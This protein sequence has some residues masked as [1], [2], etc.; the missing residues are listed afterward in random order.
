MMTADGI[1]LSYLVAAAVAAP[2]VAAAAARMHRHQQTGRHVS[3]PLYQNRPAST[4]ASTI[5]L[6]LQLGHDLPLGRRSCCFPCFKLFA[7]I[8]SVEDFFPTTHLIIHSSAVVTTASHSPATHRSPR[9][10][11]LITSLLLENNTTKRV[12]LLCNHTCAYA[13]AFVFVYVLVYGIRLCIHNYAD[14]Y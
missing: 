9:F 1:L 7:S 11:P 14:G 3:A 2:T 4:S 5:V 12:Q 6:T 13:L 8:P 10:Q